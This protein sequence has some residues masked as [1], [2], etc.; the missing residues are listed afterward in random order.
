VHIVA[1]TLWAGGLLALIVHLRRFPELLRDVLPRFSAAALLCVIA[2]G[3]SGLGTSVLMLDGW[4]QLW[5]SNRG[6]RILVKTVALGALAAFGARHR[7][8][9]V[10]EACSGRLLPLLRLGAIELALMGATIGIAVVLSTTA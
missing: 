2:V 6:Q 8:R 3:T 10:G 1:A 9:T 4:A 5:G 7:L